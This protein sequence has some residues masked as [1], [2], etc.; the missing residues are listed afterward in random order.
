MAGQDAGRTPTG[1]L[2]THRIA[3]GGQVRGG[4]E[5]HARQLPGTLDDETG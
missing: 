5:G 1:V 4:I 2:S 3:V